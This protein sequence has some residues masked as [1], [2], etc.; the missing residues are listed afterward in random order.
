MVDMYSF[1]GKYSE[2]SIGKTKY[3]NHKIFLVLVL[4]CYVVWFK[5]RV[6]IRQEVAKKELL[7]RIPYLLYSVYVRVENLHVTENK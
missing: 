2:K 3:I 1:V 6:I 7:C 5:R 4:F